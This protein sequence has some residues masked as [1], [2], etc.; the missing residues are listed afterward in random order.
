M[1]RMTAITT[2]HR[3]C[4]RRSGVRGLRDRAHLRRVVAAQCVV[5]VGLH[6]R[7]ARDLVGH[8]VGA[9]LDLDDVWR[10]RLPRREASECPG[11]PGARAL[12]DALLF[13][14]LLAL[15]EACLLALSRAL[16]LSLRLSLRLALLRALRLAGREALLVDDV[17]ARRAGVEVVAL[18][19]LAD[20]VA[21]EIAAHAE[22]G[23]DHHRA[24]PPPGAGLTTGRWRAVGG[25]G[26]GPRG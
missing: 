6:L 15:L 13:A 1:G 17:V 14:L 11:R 7:A 20:V 9:G 3:S 16:R 5:G 2:R 4:S 25:L 19:A 21:D 24:D 23:G 18:V 8:R 10:A 26:V 12:L 22:H